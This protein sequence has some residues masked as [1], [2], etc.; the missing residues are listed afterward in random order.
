MY[1]DWP[2]TIV[3]IIELNG[4]W[5]RKINGE[6]KWKS[7]T[8]ELIRRRRNENQ[9]S[10]AHKTIAYVWEM[11]YWVMKMGQFLNG[12]VGTLFLMIYTN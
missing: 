3:T 4:Q 1:T 7:N 10:P 2:D 5:Q 6:K 8:G 9:K 12:V 11:G